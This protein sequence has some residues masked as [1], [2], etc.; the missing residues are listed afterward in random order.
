MNAFMAYVAKGDPEEKRPNATTQ[1]Y[2]LAHYSDVVADLVKAGVL[3]VARDHG[4]VPCH[5]LRPGGR[6]A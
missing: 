3:R 2:V 4:A 6:Q 1:S 5:D